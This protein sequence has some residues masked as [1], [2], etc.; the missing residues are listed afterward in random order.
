MQEL[1][2]NGVQAFYTYLMGLDLTDFHEHVKPPMT[3]AK[4]TMIDYSRAG[5][6]TFY[7]EW[8]TVTQNSL[9]SPVNQ[10]SFIKRLVNGPEQLE[11]IKSV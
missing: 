9:M 2:T 8:K 6:D 10:S 1:K 11:S 5:F 7:H 4:R 3:I